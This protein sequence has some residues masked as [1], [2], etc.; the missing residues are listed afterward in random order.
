MK[1]SLA[2][3]GITACKKL[4]L[5]APTHLTPCGRISL[6]ITQKTTL[7]LASHTLPRGSPLGQSR[8]CGCNPHPALPSF[9]GS[10]PTIGL[11]RT[12]TGLTKP[13]PVDPVSALR[14][15]LQV[16]KGSFSR[17][18]LAVSDASP[19]SHQQLSTSWKKKSLCWIR[20]T[21]LTSI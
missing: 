11:E 21:Y 18:G 12:S 15:K 10:L 20:S 7:H 17:S 8:T 19:L 13:R 3:A 4:R 14:V 16:C 9:Q 2:P 6:S 1:A 5:R